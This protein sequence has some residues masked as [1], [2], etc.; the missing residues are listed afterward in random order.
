MLS[1]NFLNSAASI[2]SILGLFLSALALYMEFKKTAPGNQPQIAVSHTANLLVKNEVS[3]KVTSSDSSD[4]DMLFFIVIAILMG[5]LYKY[6]TYFISAVTLVSLITIFVVVLGIKLSFLNA[7]RKSIVLVSVYYI[8]TFSALF[9]TNTS[10]SHIFSNI[11]NLINKAIVILGLLLLLISAATLSFDIFKA[12][13]RKHSYVMGKNKAIL[14]FFSSI[15]GLLLTSGLFVK[16]II[17]I[18]NPVWMG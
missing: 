14:F 13:Y 17:A 9:L 4:N 18:C 1:S 3:V 16:I 7:E 6:I 12:I 2:S 15:F 11:E 8:I 5:G 10:L